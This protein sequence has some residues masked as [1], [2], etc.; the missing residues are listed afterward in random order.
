MMVGWKDGWIDGG[1]HGR[2][3]V[4]WYEGH[5]CQRQV[6]HQHHR[7]HLKNKAH[8]QKCQTPRAGNTWDISS[9]TCCS[10]CSCCCFVLLPWRTVKKAAARLR[11]SES[12]RESGVLL[13]AVPLFP[14]SLADVR[15]YRQYCYVVRPVPIQRHVCVCVDA[16]RA[17]KAAASIGGC[18][19]VAAVCFFSSYLGAILLS[20]EGWFRGMWSLPCWFRR[21]VQILHTFAACVCVCWFF[22]LLL[23]EPSGLLSVVL[24]FAQLKSSTRIHSSSLSLRLL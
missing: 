3:R 22:C 21:A 2:G 17:V 8:S 10:C 14:V 23:E 1:H 7:R 24:L 6:N 11:G 15:I 16:S 13:N 9:W 20:L 18:V 19:R 4:T 12:R 5:S